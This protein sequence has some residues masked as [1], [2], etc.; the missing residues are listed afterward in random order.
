MPPTERLLQLLDKN[1]DFHPLMQGCYD[2]APAVVTA[3]APRGWQRHNSSCC[4]DLVPR[5]GDVYANRGSHGG[6]PYH[7]PAGQ[8]HAEVHRT[9]GPRRPGTQPSLFRAD[10]RPVTLHA[11]ANPGAFRHPAK[12]SMH[13]HVRR[14]FLQPRCSM[15]GKEQHLQ[16]SQS[17]T[18]T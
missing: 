5:N 13:H 4:S 2:G 10:G 14:I 12:P 18:S 7:R 3:P 17:L 6:R 11:S 1:T 15:T 8:L 9:L 16:L